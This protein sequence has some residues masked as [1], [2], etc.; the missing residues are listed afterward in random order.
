[1][2]HA[3]AYQLPTLKAHLGP[4]RPDPKYLE[5]SLSNGFLW[6]TFKSQA[7]QYSPTL[8][9]L[10]F[11]EEWT[12]QLLRGWGGN[13][14][15]G[16][17]QTNVMENE[18]FAQNTGDWSSKPCVALLVTLGKSLAFFEPQHHH[19]NHEQRQPRQC[20]YVLQSVWTLLCFQAFSGEW[21]SQ[22][23]Q[24]ERTVIC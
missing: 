3:M 22:S 18:N 23:I 24:R 2:N 14:A 20:R 7:R 12:T 13:S 15:R 11:L 17:D 9:T 10:A 8:E 5:I 6:D 16:F 1:M 21:K 19:K 4:S